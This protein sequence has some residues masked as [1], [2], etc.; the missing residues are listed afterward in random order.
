MR[1]VIVDVKIRLWIDMDEGQDVGDVIDEMYYVFNASTDHNA[2]IVDTS[3][4][5]FEVLDSK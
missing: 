4:E 5:D 2:T 1:T 3:I